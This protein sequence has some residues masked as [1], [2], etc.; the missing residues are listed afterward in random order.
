MSGRGPSFGRRT[1]L[2]SGVGVSA[3]AVVASAVGQR[4][5][6]GA[7][8]AQRAAGRAAAAGSTGSLRAGS[9]SVNGLTDPVGVDP[10]DCSF[11]WTLTAQGRAVVQ[12]GYRLVVRRADPGHRGLTWDSGVVA[13]ARQ[14]FVTY[15]GPTLA[16]DASYRWTVQARGPG[17]R[18]G[19]V[20]GPAHF[21]TALREADWTARWLQPAAASPQPDR[22]TY[23][24]TD[25]TLPDGAI[26]RATAYISAAHTYQL[27]VDGDRVDAWPSFSYP[28]EQYLRSID[29]T[30][31]ITGGR[32]SAVGVLHR[33]Y[34]AGKGRP[35]SAPGLIVQLSVWYRDGRNV[36]VGTDENWREQTAEWLPS[37]QRNNDACDFVEWIDGRRHPAGWSGAHYDDSAWGQVTV[38]GPAGTAPFTRTYAQRTQITERALAPV[39]VRS[40]RSGSVVVDFGAVYAARPQVAFRSGQ[41]GR[42]IPMRVGY[43]LD[44][45]GQVS[46]T[47]GTQVTNLSFSYIQREGAQ[48]FE[49]LCFLGFRYLQIDGAGEPIGP[50]Q[51]TAISRHAKMPG[52]AMATFSTG[53]RIL[54]AVWKLNARSCLYCCHEQF[55]DT[56][57]REKAQ[58]L[59]DAANESEAVMRTYGDQNMSWQGLRDVARGQARFHPD[60]RVNVV[61]PYGFGAR[62]IPTFTERYPEWLWRYYLSTGDLDTAVLLYPSTAQV[63]DYLWSARQP[64]TGL[65][66]GLADVPEGDPTYGYDTA[67]AADTA[68]NVLGVNA[69]NRVA[70]LAE[71][72][73]DAAGAATQR[74][75]S[76]QLAAAINALLT[77]ADGTYVDGVDTNGAQSAHASQEANAL[78]LAYGVVPQAKV[79]QVGAYV[80]S[81]GIDVGPNHG[82]ELM[83]ALAAAGMPAAMVRT[84]TDASVPGWAHILA[85]GGTFTWETWT[86]SDLIGDSMSHGWGSAALVA[87][88]ET[89]LGVSPLEPGAGGTVRVL[90]NPPSN[91]IA[92]ASG[93]VPTVAGPVSAQ[94][95]RSGTRLSL[96]L[97]VPPNASAHISMPAPS[98][99]AVREGG[100]PA[101]SSP[102]I[103]VLSDSGGSIVF[104]VGSGTY[105]FTVA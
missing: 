17:G 88:Q 16:S 52:V 42:T 104:S 50:G 61:Y 45:D 13:T 87:M 94:W 15:G 63:S 30:G 84:L 23:V 55:V 56:P 33:W 25:I 86:P 5:P 69:F 99:S 37:P 70:Q 44:P 82:L 57:T 27:Y 83:R 91:G 6:E 100:V 14:A 76:A 19:P 77:R 98:A 75:R 101:T 66:Y 65:L 97:S 28:D 64:G 7:A 22:I 72:A 54:D 12:T 24:R 103:Q 9:V 58:F 49:A 21:T 36:V 53:N 89:L 80:A 39:R 48:V 51:V 47:H 59:W 46:T 32:P 90:V 74:Q 71:L 78:A 29:L 3:G 11:A 34:G 26:A 95:R 8:A 4:A 31:R 41:A 43:L 102:G 60:G 1:F 79:A 85:A 73:G 62:D 2:A 81:L 40:L 96:D 92:A 38:L 35:E 20:S 18:W 68:S 67:V 93:S 10:D 105:R